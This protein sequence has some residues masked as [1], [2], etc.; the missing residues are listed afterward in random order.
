MW[1]DVHVSLFDTTTNRFVPGTQKNV[2]LSPQHKRKHT[3][4]H[5]HMPFPA[6]PQIRMDKVTRGVRKTFTAQI[7]DETIGPLRA[8]VSS[9]IAFAVRACTLTLTV[10]SRH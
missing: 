1:V 3:Q 2:S 10:S 6:R 9:V 5:A 7:A 4:A 8:I